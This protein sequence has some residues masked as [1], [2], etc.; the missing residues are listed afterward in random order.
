MKSQAELAHKTRH[1]WV[2][3]NDITH[4]NTVCPNSKRT[5]SQLNLQWN[6]PPV[7]RGDVQT[8]PSEAAPDAKLSTEHVENCTKR[9][10]GRSF[11]LY[12]AQRE[13]QLSLWPETFWLNRGEFAGHQLKPNATVRESAAKDAAGES[14]LR[15]L[16]RNQH[17]PAFIFTDIRFGHDP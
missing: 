3:F 12:S 1:E 2:I 11:A 9:H 14:S 15:M 8:T 6:T 5:V 16:L 10:P 17:S 13:A 4:K 7:T